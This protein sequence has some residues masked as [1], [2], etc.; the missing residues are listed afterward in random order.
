MTNLDKPTNG[1][2]RDSVSMWKIW[3]AI[4]SLSVMAIWADNHS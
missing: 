4:F 2:E 1:S 3:R